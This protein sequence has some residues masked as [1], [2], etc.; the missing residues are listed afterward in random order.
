MSTSIERYQQE[1][2]KQAAGL[3]PTWLPGDRID[4]GDVGILG[5]GRFRR[6]TSLPELGISLELDEPGSPNSLRYSSTKETKLNFGGG[7]SLEESLANIAS[8]SARVDIKFGAEGAFLF[9][10]D[11]V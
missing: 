5:G 3:F 10:A 8:A 11:G 9:H 2:C 6:S 7:A 1:L 4:P